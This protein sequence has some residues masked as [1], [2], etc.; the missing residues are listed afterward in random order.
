MEKLS[1]V[2]PASPRVKSVDLKNAKPVRPGA[3]RFGAP[4]GMTSR[5]R[6]RLMISEQAKEMA[7]SETMAAKNPREMRQVQMV[8]DV[9]RRFF[10]TRLN[11]PEP[12]VMA[13]GDRAAIESAEE[14]EN[15][16]EE[17]AVIKTGKLDVQA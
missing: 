6:D 12:N 8:D 14:P 11:Q 15:F 17:S 10:E 7:F 5:E 1:S 2:L 9:T 16:V 13:R 3:P 4:N